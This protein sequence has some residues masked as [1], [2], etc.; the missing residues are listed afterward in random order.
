MLIFKTCYFKRKQVKD[1]W[2][3]QLLN[4]HFKS[5]NLLKLLNRLNSSLFLNEPK[6]NLI[7]NSKLTL[8]KLIKFSHRQDLKQV[9]LK[10]Q[11]S[12]NLR[13]SLLIKKT[14]KVIITSI[15]LTQF[16]ETLISKQVIWMIQ[17][18]KVLKYLKKNMRN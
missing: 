4:L 7:I 8:I 9:F 5:S 18:T 3:L 12:I 16:K 6:L 10:F 13:Q 17:M 11:S 1:R 2:L 14:F 15:S